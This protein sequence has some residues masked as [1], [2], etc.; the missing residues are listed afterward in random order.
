[1]TETI[2]IEN[3][4]NKLVS[5]AQL[6]ANRLNAQKSTGPKDTSQTRFNATKHGLLSQKVFRIVSDEERELIANLSGEVRELIGQKREVT[7][8]DE[9]LIEKLIIAWWRVRRA[10]EADVILYQRWYQRGIEHD[11]VNHMLDDSIAVKK[12]DPRTDPKAADLVLSHL[13][14]ETELI[15]RYAVSAENSFYRVLDM[16]MK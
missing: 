10:A 13:T 2:D 1:M 7:V 3:G 14:D 8:I 6:E 11:V 12:T 16:L 9:I 15:R 4:L 5:K